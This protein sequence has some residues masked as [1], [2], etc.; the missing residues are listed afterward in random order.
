MKKL[1]FSICAFI[2]C[3]STYAQTGQF[4]IDQSSVINAQPLTSCKASI[5]K[6]EPANNQI[7]WGYQ[8]GDEERSAVGVSKAETYYASLYIAPSNAVIAGK[9]IK[10]FRFYLRDKENT[11]DV[12][13]W[14]SKNYLK[15]STM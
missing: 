4:Q 7:W 6:I 2:L 5:N 14:I 10:A 9:T 12:K 13:I 3:I 8:E 11:K 15:I 1:L